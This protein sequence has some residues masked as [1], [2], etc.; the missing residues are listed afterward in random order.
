MFI[1]SPLYEWLSHNLVA[2]ALAVGAVGAI[3]YYLY[4]ASTKKGRYRQ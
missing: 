4:H 3:A 1:G 2:I